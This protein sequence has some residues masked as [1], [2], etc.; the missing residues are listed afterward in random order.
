MAQQPR[1]SSFDAFQRATAALHQRRAE[2]RRARSDQVVV[3][4]VTSA[5]EAP[6]H[7]HDADRS[8]GDDR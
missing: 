6:S 7:D 4:S 3:A 8:T 2:E 1:S 5:T